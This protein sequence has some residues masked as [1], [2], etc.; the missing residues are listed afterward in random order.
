MQKAEKNIE[1]QRDR[2]HMFVLYTTTF[3][4]I[5]GD[6]NQITQPPSKNISFIHACIRSMLQER[7]TTYPCLGCVVGHTLIEILFPLLFS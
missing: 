5:F 3:F 4:V 6:R 2:N 1:I 7:V